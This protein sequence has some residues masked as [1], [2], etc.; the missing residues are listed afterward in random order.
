[1]RER[2][3]EGGRGSKGESGREEGK[4]EGR[5]GEREGEKNLLP[6][7]WAEKAQSM[8]CNNRASIY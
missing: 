1:M 4:E 5:D 7:S 6:I 8:F 3:R 2:E